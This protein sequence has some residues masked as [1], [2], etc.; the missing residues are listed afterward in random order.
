MTQPQDRSVADLHTWLRDRL[1][2]PGRAWLEQALGDAAAAAEIPLPPQKPAD[3]APPDLAPADFAPAAW[4]L[5]FAAA[6]RHCGRSAPR[7]AAG[8]AAA[9]REDGAHPAATPRNATPTTPTEPADAARILLLH[10]ARADSTTATRLYTHGTAAE[11]RAVLLALPHLDAGS[12]A[13]GPSAVPLVED[14]LRANDTRLV[15][16]AVGPYAARYL[17]PHTWRHAVLKCLFTGVAVTAVAQ[18]AHRARGDAEL[19]RMLTDHARERRA[20]GRPVPTDLH[21]V[22]AL[23]GTTAAT[24]GTDG[25]G[26]TSPSEES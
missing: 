9:T 21:H 13:L 20:A 15:A 23:T 4:E 3:L 26:T 24:G 17:E 18:L 2:G 14:A 8:P 10:A 5:H 16:A 11:R 19:G 7:D 22:L 1:G 12:A 6:G 25:T